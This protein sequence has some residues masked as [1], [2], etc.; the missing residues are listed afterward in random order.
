MGLGSILI[1]LAMLLFGLAAFLWPPLV[2]PWRLRMIA[3]G[4]MCWTL[5]LLVGGLRL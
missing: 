5:S 3:A 1:V 4:L 2:D